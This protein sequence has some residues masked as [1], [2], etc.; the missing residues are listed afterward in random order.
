MLL[1]QGLSNPFLFAVAHTNSDTIQIFSQ[2]KRNDCI[3]Q[4][5]YFTFFFC[6]KKKVIKEKS[7][8]F[9]LSRT[10]LSDVVTAPPAIFYNIFARGLPFAA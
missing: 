4:I 2:I 5:Y 10:A 6:E 1:S 7:S 3:L 9:M 8:V